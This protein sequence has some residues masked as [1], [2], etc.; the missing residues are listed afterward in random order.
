MSD[1][2]I[3]RAAFSLNPERPI[4]TLAGLTRAPRSTAKSWATGRRRPSVIILEIL[5]DQLKIRQAALFQLVAE[6]DCIITQRER[7]SK[8]RTGFNIIDPMTG[9]DRRNRRGRPRRSV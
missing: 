7:E 2:L 9:L 4:M 1:T 3:R 5:R 6:L 8:R